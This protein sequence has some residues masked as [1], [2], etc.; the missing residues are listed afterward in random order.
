LPGGN[1]VKKNDGKYSNLHNISI[2]ANYT[3]ANA[4]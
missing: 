4:H 3:A 1:R 2:Y